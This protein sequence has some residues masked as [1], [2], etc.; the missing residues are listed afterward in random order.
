MWFLLLALSIVDL[1]RVE[2]N[3]AGADRQHR[4]HLDLDH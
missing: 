3:E 4:P 1:G 2:K